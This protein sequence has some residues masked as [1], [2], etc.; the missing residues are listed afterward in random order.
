MLPDSINNNSD[1]LLLN[2]CSGMGLS[3]HSVILTSTC[4]GNKPI[5]RGGNESSEV[6]SYLVKVRELVNDPANIACASKVLFILLKVS[7]FIF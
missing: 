5:F 2:V 6:S 3:P 1:A 7:D 4:N